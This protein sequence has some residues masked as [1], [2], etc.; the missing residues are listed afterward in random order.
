[1]DP[2][3][4]EIWAKHPAL[5][6]LPASLRETAHRQ[7]FA[8]DELLYR[9]GQ[10]PEAM[11]CVLEGEIRLVRSARAG[12]QVLLQRS[13]GGFIAEASMDA[14]AYHCDIVAAE[15]GHLLAFPLAAFRTALER[16]L[17]FNAAWI[18]RLSR[19]LR[20]QRARSERLSLNS[21]AERILHFIEAEGEGGAIRLTESRKAW[22]AE[23][24]LSHEALYRALAR[25][26]RDGTLV[27][28]GPR[29]ALASDTT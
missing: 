26:Q 18:A 19:E 24:G 6:D 17:A 3:W 7:D 14:A 4:D 23:L 21:A 8:T 11:L 29:I 20:R 1:M 5:R 16:S 22:A 25:L 27:I 9:R 2:D 10:P 15:D 28:S 13:R 12:T